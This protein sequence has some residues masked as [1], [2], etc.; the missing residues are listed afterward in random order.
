MCIRDRL[1]TAAEDATA[2]DE[3]LARQRPLD[4]GQ[5]RPVAQAWQAWRAASERLWRHGRELLRQTDAG[6]GVNLLPAMLAVQAETTPVQAAASRLV[7]ALRAEACLLYT[8]PSPRDRTRSR[9]P[10][11]A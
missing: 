10:S 9:M 4:A 1:D 8:S 6:D 2:L 5:D 7:A 3:R 11:S